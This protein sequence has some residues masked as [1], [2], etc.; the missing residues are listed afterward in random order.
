MKT[1]ILIHFFLYLVIA[2]LSS[3][4]SY[5]QVTITVGTIGSFNY[6]NNTEY[7]SPYAQ[8]NKSSHQQFLLTASEIVTAGGMAGI[9]TAIGFDVQ[10]TNAC[11]A[12]PAYTIKM[13]STTAT[14]LST[15]DNSGL[16][17]VFYAASYTPIA[18]WNTHTFT[19]SISWNGTSN[20]LVDLCNSLSSNQTDNASCYL[21][22]STG[23]YLLGTSNTSNMC[24][25]SSLSNTANVRP[26]VQLTIMPNYPNC[27][28]LTSPANGA[29]SLARNT[30][31]AWSSGGGSPTSYDIYFGTNPTPPYVLNKTGTTYNPGALLGS[32]DY[33]W[34]IVPRN[35]YGTATGCPVWTF[36]T[37]SG[38]PYCVTNLSPADGMV[39]VA[40]QPTLNWTASSGATRYRI[41]LG[42]LPNP[43]LFDSTS[44]TTYI[45]SNATASNQTYYW[46]I[47]PKGSYEYRNGC[48]ERQFT[49]YSGCVQNQSPA[50]GS[51]NLA[52]Y[53]TLNWSVI[54][55]AIKYYIYFGTSI[56]PSLHDSTSSLSYNLTDLMTGTTYYW[57]IVTRTN[58]GF[59]VGCPVLSFTTAPCN[60]WFIKTN[61]NDGLSGNS[62][63]N[64]KQELSTVMLNAIPGDTIHVAAGTYHPN[65]DTTGNFFPS[66]LRDLTFTLKSGVKLIGGYP[67]SASGTDLAT[68]LL[69]SHDPYTNIT[70]L[71]GDIGSANDSTDNAYHVIYEKKAG[72]GTS[73]L[74]G[75]TISNGFANGAI[76]IKYCGP[77]IYNDKGDLYL[78][79]CI[80]TRNSSTAAS[81]MGGGIYCNYSN[82]QLYEC[83]IQ[84]NFMKA[85]GIAI[86]MNHGVL[87][88][89]NSTIVKNTG[90]GYTMYGIYINFS[91][92]QVNN[93]TIRE[94]SGTDLVIDNYC[95]K[96]SIKN[97][98]IGSLSDNQALSER[99]L[100]I[101]SLIQSANLAPLKYNSIVGNTYYDGNGTSF[102]MPTAYT[103]T[104]LIL[105]L[106]DNGGHTWTYRLNP[107]LAYN[108]AV[109]MGNPS[110]AGQT[111]Q[112]GVIRSNRPCI[113]AYE[114]IYSKASDII[115]ND[116]AICSGNSVTLH[117]S[118][119]TIVNPQFKWY[120][121]SL[122][123]NLLFTGD[124]FTTPILNTSANYFIV[125]NNSTIYPNPL[126]YVKKI[127]VY[128]TNSIIINQQ[129]LP[130]AVCTG[131]N[132]TFSVNAIGAGL[133]YQWMK[134]GNPMTGDTNSILTL[135][136]VSVL[137]TGL[138]SCQM[139][140]TCGSQMNTGSALFS[141][142]SFPSVLQH[143]QSLS[144]CQNT[145]ALFSVFA[146]GSGITYQWNKNGIVMNGQ[147]N[148]TLLLHNASIAD[149]G[150]YTCTISGVCGSPL[151]SNAAVL[152]VK[153]TPGTLY[154]LDS[155]YCSNSSPVTLSA[156]PSGG[157]FTGAG[158][159]GNT[160]SP[161]NAGAGTHLIT[162]NFIDS[163][164]CVGY[165]NSTVT[166][167]ICTGITE[168]L[169]EEQII[170]YPNPTDGQIIININGFH[171]FATLEVFDI[172]GNKFIDN[173]LDVNPKP[174]DIGYLS[175]GIYLLLVKTEKNI[176]RKKI[177]LK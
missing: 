62:W 120:S 138:Y 1:N 69:V 51:T 24:G 78:K 88:I 17:S 79:R 145:D 61:G 155:L 152:I 134:N 117:V 98:T 170:V 43:P 39:G 27:A 153:Y 73:M 12:L 85:Y 110:F 162:Y 14:S 163:N 59:T 137:D 60:N 131:N 15:M 44:S 100:L 67:T 52:N 55:G 81:S 45:V 149:T 140:N 171:G 41:Y 115:I 101:N 57:K 108:P 166:V 16:T 3:A 93:S 154:G 111:D 129:P 132:A 90:S 82:A 86:Y 72:Q 126:I 176:L 70:T 8:L 174:L 96:D 10:S 33:Y 32:T 80:L 11:G 133:T 103:M 158:M 128:V 38:I 159:T 127:R 141:L 143:P 135:H 102:T 157:T 122:R 109:G 87:K 147:N 148:D 175:P 66:D 114:A 22:Q 168:N 49:T 40:F 26:T 119:N 50:D 19:S 91:S 36:N 161:Q 164:S 142:L 95:Y 4:K 121:D 172:T 5:G 18:G 20:I 165:I 89:S 113:G 30:T 167:D 6:N 21:T 124:T 160:F 136:N 130:N 105:P 83:T 37:N 71:S 99:A 169:T 48:E 13:K 46:R 54:P 75:F 173:R 53:Q 116:T 31:L 68:S 106:A 47:A 35:S 92:I 63:D 139:T 9:I 150:T 104:N 42:T 177:I 151:T 84:K 77:G 34:K 97:S 7:P 94:N 125:V 146:S 76:A 156:Y 112:R 144:I 56:N 123:T 74:D 28:N 23:S 107:N 58:S 29:D 25:T 64:A 2:I 118:S 65:C